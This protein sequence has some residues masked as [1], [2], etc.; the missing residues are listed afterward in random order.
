VLDVVVRDKKGRPV[1]DLEAAQFE[2]GDNGEPVKI[3][4]FRLVDR[5]TEQ[6]SAAGAGPKAADGAGKLDPARQ[7]RLVTLL[8]E[9]LGQDGRLLARRAALDLIKGAPEPNTYY[10]VF[11]L[12]QRLSAIQQFTSDRGLL[13]SAIEHVTSGA[14]TQ[15]A[16]DSERVKH[17]LEEQIG[18]PANTNGESQ[19]TQIDA[20]A[21]PRGANASQ[22]Q[23]A[24]MMLATLQFD[25]SISADQAGRASIFGLLSLVREQ[26]RL[27]G[28][29]TLLY[30]TE[31][32]F[33][34]D[35]LDEPFRAIISSANRANVSIYA[36]DSRGLQTG[37]ENQ[38]AADTL[39]SAAD[40]SREQAQATD[41][42]VRPDQAKVFDTAIASMRSNT[43]N[44]LVE[45]AQGTGGFLVANS[46]DLR[47]PLRRINEDINSYY[48][49]IYKPDIKEF[50]GSFRKIS[51]KVARADA[52]VQS[53]SG[54]FALPSLGGAAVEPFEYAALRA[55]DTRPLPHAFD[56]RS[57]AL[58]FRPDGARVQYAIAFEVPNRNLG[59]NTDPKTKAHAVHASFLALIKDAQ[60]QVVDKVSRDIPAVVPD[61]KFA[62]FQNGK[63]I[64]TKQ[65]DLAPGR[66]MLETAV[67]DRAGDRASARRAVL[68]VPA[69]APH[70]PA[71]SAV[72]VVRRLD[73]VQP[74]PFT[75]DPYE[76]PGGRVTPSL[77]DPVPSA[78]PAMLYFV[79]YPMKDSSDKPAVTIEFLRNGTVVAQ[80]SPPLAAL[81]ANG[82]VPMIVQAKLETGDYEVRV[83]LTQGNL[84]VSQ[85]VPLVVE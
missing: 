59:A 19:V 79:A 39:R 38:S 71:L 8:F 29:K 49:I 12:D 85:G 46:N 54:Y 34:P 28:R 84:R 41:G 47:T 83:A 7:I 58:R 23:M 31:G 68:V 5:S 65:V 80:Q 26:Y 51:V 72:S 44:S 20:L 82:A 21:G 75:S 78:S 56:F 32:L 76:F 10:A 62:A 55:L 77:S 37:G 81:D 22:V 61:D 1:R 15:F 74:H 11:A 63:F 73:A 53:R 16:A 40:S 57:A 4:S 9:R 66:Y 14:S 6:D 24:R 18:K 33:V 60:G 13:K 69:P 30:F 36:I 42:A 48:E 17:E 45:L 2:V 3:S 35:N 64:F 43:N 27:P 25:Q 50:D 52:K 67:V 70:A